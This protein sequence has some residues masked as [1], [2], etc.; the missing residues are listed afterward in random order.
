MSDD[1]T[2]DEGEPMSDE[3]LNGPGLL[4]E[5]FS[6]PAENGDALGDV[7]I[8]ATDATDAKTP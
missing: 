3:V 1:A 7:A 6:K 2:D 8:G 5:L 4:D